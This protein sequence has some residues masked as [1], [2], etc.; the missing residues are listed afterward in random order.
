MRR[1]VRRILI[2]RTMM[3]CSYSGQTGAHLQLAIM[4][5]S[6][7]L[8]PSHRHKSTIDELTSSGCEEWCKSMHYACIMH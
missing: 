4:S 7:S 8:Q 2:G 6:R 5:R 1:R 3:R